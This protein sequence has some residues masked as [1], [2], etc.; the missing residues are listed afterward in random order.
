LTGSPDIITRHQLFCR[1]MDHYVPTNTHWT[2][3]YQSTKKKN[4]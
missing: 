4:I 1:V 3:I 2:G